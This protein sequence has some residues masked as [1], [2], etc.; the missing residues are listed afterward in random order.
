MV[1]EGVGVR[2]EVHPHQICAFAQSFDDHVASHVHLI[3]VVACSA[4]ER[5]DACT[6]VERIGQCIAGE[7]VGQRVAGEARGGAGQQDGVFD[8][9]A[10]RV[11]AGA[12]VDPNLIGAG[13]RSFHDQVT[14]GVHFIGVVARA[15][16]QRIVARAAHQRVIA[17]EPAQSVVAAPADE[18]VGHRVARDDVCKARARGVFDDGAVGNAQGV[19]HVGAAVPDGSAHR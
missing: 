3:G 14:G 8:V 18:M 13:V 1:V 6:A 5:V 4:F 19:T 9:V 7:V 15:A 16:L 10:Q 17:V 11:G 12:E 2:G